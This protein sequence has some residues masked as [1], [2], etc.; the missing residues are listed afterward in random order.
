MLLESLGIPVGVLATE[1]YQ[2]NGFIAAQDDGFTRERKIV[3]CDIRRV[4]FMRNGTAPAGR[5]VPTGSSNADMSNTQDAATPNHFDIASVYANRALPNGRINLMIEQYKLPPLSPILLQRIDP[6]NPRKFAAPEQMWIDDEHWAMSAESILDQCVWAA[7]GPETAEDKNPHR[8][9][10]QELGPLNTGV[11]GPA[12][13]ITFTAPTYE[14]AVWKFMDFAK[15]NGFNDGLALI[16]PTPE[17]V[18]EMLATTTRD[19]NDVLGYVYLRGGAMTVEKLAI[20]AVMSGLK[21][22]AFPV[23]LAAGEAL[24]HG[25]EENQVWWHSMTG[26][27]HTLAFLVSGPVVDEIGMSTGLNQSGGGNEVNNTLGRAVRMLWRNIAN[28]IQPNLD[29]SDRSYRQIETMIITLA[30]N[31]K[32]TREVGWPTHSETCGF[33]ENSSCVVLLDVSGSGAGGQ[34][35]SNAQGWTTAWTPTALLNLLPQGDASSLATLASNPG[36]GFSG[37]YGGLRTYTPAQARLLTATYASKQAIIDARAPSTE[38]AQNNPMSPN[39][40]PADPY[41][42]TGNLLSLRFPLIVGDDPD[43]SH[44]MQNSFHANT[45]FVNQ[46]INGAAGVAAASAP[47]TVGETAPSAPQNFVVGPLTKEEGKDTYSAKLT[48]DAPKTD[49]GNLIDHYEVYYLSGLHEL[50]FRW[51]EVPGGAAAREATFTNLLP[52]V[53]YEF[54]IRARNKVDNAL[55]YFTNGGE[56]HIHYMFFNPR[57]QNLSKAERIDRIGGRGGWAV[58]PPVTPPGRET[59]MNSN[60]YPQI[61]G[62]QGIKLYYSMPNT[63]TPNKLKGDLRYGPNGEIWNPAGDRVDRAYVPPGP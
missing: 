61:Q 28:N 52:G 13:E 51:V 54:K 21:P 63:W 16:P 33:G 29:I 26:N 31:Y 35:A 38:V 34:L 50:A 53:Q 24:G 2:T 4:A 6:V 43:G 36:L 30:E 55:L 12:D 15:K 17:R 49:G 42:V 59:K 57:F 5:A 11:I 9:Q 1:T 22:E 60:R 44:T 23:Y 37:N 46:K 14:K 32:A 19:R 8:I 47:S 27:T 45:T 56:L 39:Y 48:W 18:N 41:G 3:I 40:D 20:N 7:I 62:Q 58:A 10:P 25:W